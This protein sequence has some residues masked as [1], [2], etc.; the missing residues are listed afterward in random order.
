MNSSATLKI[1][2]T[3]VQP[4][5]WAMSWPESSGSVPESKRATEAIPQPTREPVTKGLLERSDSGEL[6]ARNAGFLTV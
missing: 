6:P 5:K 2:V 1:F 3:E 4:V